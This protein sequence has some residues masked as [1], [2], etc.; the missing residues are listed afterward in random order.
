[1]FIE[2]F[3]KQRFKK[4]R[5][6]IKSKNLDLAHHMEQIRIRQPKITAAQSFIQ[7]LKTFLAILFNLIA[8]HFSYIKINSVSGN[9]L[10]PL[11]IL[12]LA[13]KRLTSLIKGGNAQS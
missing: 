3:V 4:T 2:F 5:V 9:H 11:I 7:I 12:D 10:K 6:L 8:E 1:M 13:L